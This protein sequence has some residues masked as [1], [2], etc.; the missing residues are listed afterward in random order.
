[1]LTEE[2]YEEIIRSLASHLKDCSDVINAEIIP[3]HTYYTKT[4]K[5][6]SRK[7]GYKTHIMIGLYNLSGE[8]AVR[9]MADTFRRLSEWTKEWEKE[10]FFSEYTMDSIG[11]SNSRLDVEIYFDDLTESAK[12]LLLR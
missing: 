7:K 6:D 12:K 5:W 4:G 3:F 8:R 1:M 2:K 11:G 9:I 10:I